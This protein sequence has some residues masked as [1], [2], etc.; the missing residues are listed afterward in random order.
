MDTLFCLSDSSQCID[1]SDPMRL[2]PEDPQN[3]DSPLWPAKGTIR[4][5]IGAY[6]GYELFVGINYNLV[7]TPSEFTLS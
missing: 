5:D 7:S 6:G 4:S 2:D 3:Q 1:A